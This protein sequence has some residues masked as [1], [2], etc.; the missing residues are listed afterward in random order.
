MRR[1]T[2]FIRAP[3][4]RAA[5]SIEGL[6]CSMNGVIVMITNGTDGTRFTR[7]TATSVRPS[8]TLYITVASGMP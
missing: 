7:I 5:L 1:N 6:I 2:S 8:P 3:H 4:I